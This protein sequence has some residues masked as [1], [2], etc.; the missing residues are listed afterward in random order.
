MIA[1]RGIVARTSNIPANG[2]CPARASAGQ[3]NANRWRKEERQREKD[4]NSNL[5]SRSDSI[6][7]LAYLDWAPR[8]ADGGGGAG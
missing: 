6:F 1:E 2:P 7:S 4:S 3:N 5:R 8:G